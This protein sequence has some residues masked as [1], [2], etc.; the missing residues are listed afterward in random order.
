MTARR[1][2]YLSTAAAIGCA[3][4]FGMSENT[5]AQQPAAAAVSIDSDDIGG[6]VTGPN[7][8]EAGVWVIAETTDLPTKLSKIVVTDDQGRYVVPDLPKSRYQVWV[9]GYGLVDSPKVESELGKELNLR[10]VP[11]PNEAAAAEYYPAIYWYSMLKIPDAKEFGTNSEIPE[12]MTQTDWLKQVK[13]IGCIGCHQLGQL[14]TRTIPAAFGEFK[15]GREAW[16]R[17]VQ[18]GQSGEQMTNQLAG[19]FGG[20]PFKYYGEWTDRI[21]KGELPHAK[22][23]RPQGLER[24]IVVTTWA[25]GTEK[26]YLHDLIASD[27]RK[28]TVNAN[29]PLYGSPEYSTDSYPILDP[30]TNTVS[31]FNAPVRDVE[32]PESLGPG[33]AASIKP[34]APSAYWADEKVWDT[35]A[36]NHNDMIDEKG[37][38]WLAAAVRGMDNPA[39]CKKGSD[40]P[41]AKIFPLEKSARQAAML[42]PKTMK[43]TFV[44]TCFGTHHLQFGY[45]ANNTLW[46]SGTGPVAGWLD[47]KLFDDT[48]DAAKAQGWTPFVLDTN[49]NGKRDDYVEPNAPV[50]PAKD[51]RIVPGSG[52]YAVMPS[53]VDGSI[54]YTVGIFSGTPAVLRLMPGDSPSETALAEIYNVPKPGFGIRGGDI[55]KNGVVWASLSSGHLASFDRRKCKVLNGPTATGDHCPEGWTLYQYPGPGFE[56][57]GENSAESSY[58]TWVDQHNTFGLGENVPMSTGNLNDG[59][60]ALKDGKMIVLRVPYPLGFYAKGFDGRIDDPNAGWKGRGLWTTSGDRTPWLKEGGKGTKPIAVHFQLRP[61][62][63]AH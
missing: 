44:D 49:G 36:N 13:N 6:V 19:Q 50:D 25:W 29:G 15:S 34:L 60:I 30:K 56:G 40:H 59:L 54:W 43:Y 31:F 61:D 4:F 35:R 5:Q 58:Y 9:R 18:S 12:K 27:R 20:A 37:R 7:G 11:A 38:V 2:F 63:L 47:T 41:S 51:K 23:S 10:A 32:M 8:P 33:H 62:P 16:M 17:R 48:G 22:P 24:N 53:P 26:Q 52:P 39:F 45:D 21:A 46:F 14:S 1:K 57:L 55:D 28:P 3:V 42:D